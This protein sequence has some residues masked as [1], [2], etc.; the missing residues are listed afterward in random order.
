MALSMFSGT[1][2]GTSDVRK[3]DRDHDERSRAPEA[4]FR[5]AARNWPGAIRT[6][7]AGRLRLPIDEVSAI[8]DEAEGNR[9]EYR[10]VRLKRCQ[11]ADPSPADAQHE[12][13]PSAAAI[14][15]AAVSF[16]RRPIAAASRD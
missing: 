2:E 15:P 7:R 1:E 12:A 5:H 13:A 9:R 4:N 16:C 3:A 8:A 11:V 10:L 14:P 6:V